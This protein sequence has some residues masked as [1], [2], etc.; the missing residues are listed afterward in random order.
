MIKITP[1][2]SQTDSSSV[3]WYAVTFATYQKTAHE[4]ASTI[5][6]TPAITGRGMGVA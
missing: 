4:S 1:N 2:S 3:G 5:T 6:H